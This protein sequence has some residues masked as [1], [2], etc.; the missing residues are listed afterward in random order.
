MPNT[1]T[2]NGHALDKDINVTASDVGALSQATADLRY[3]LKAGDTVIGNL[4]I[5]GDLL[6]RKNATIKGNMSLEQ[7]LKLV[8]NLN[9]DGTIRA[10]GDVWAFEPAAGKAGEAPV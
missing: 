4:T 1:R 10:T 7:I 5:N 9:V 2:I 6:A 8:N 3:L